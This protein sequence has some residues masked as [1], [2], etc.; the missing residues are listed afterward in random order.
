MGSDI[1][2]WERQRAIDE[3]QPL[4]QEVKRLSEAVKNLREQRNYY[5]EALA[6]VN[7]ECLFGDNDIEASMIKILK[8]SEAPSF[9]GQQ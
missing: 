7:T 9:E 3:Y 5:M 2:Q 4:K 1:F 6:K 8:L